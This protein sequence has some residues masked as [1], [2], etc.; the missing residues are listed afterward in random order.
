MKTAQYPSSNSLRAFVLMKSSSDALPHEKAA[1]SWC[2]PSGSI[3]NKDGMKRMRHA[4][5]DSWAVANRRTSGAGLVARC[6]SFES[7]IGLW[8]IEQGVDKRLAFASA[9]YPR[10]VLSHDRCCCLVGP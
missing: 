5:S 6:R 9:Q 8:R 10:V 2:G 1:R 4:S 3:T 7:R